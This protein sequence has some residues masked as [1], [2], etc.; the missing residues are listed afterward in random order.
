[1]SVTRGR[2]V[3]N[4]EVSHDED[5]LQSEEHRPLDRAHREAVQDLGC[6]EKLRRIDQYVYDCTVGCCACTY[7]GEP[8][9]MILVKLVHVVTSSSQ[10]GYQVYGYD[11][12]V[13]GGLHA[14][15]CQ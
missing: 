1:M 6:Q 13:E 2:G 9:D 10:V 4:L 12:A 8:S 11:V 3:T 15:M 7:L 5:A 14:A